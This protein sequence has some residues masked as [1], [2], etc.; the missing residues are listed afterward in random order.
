[1]TDF[2]AALKRMS[3]N[4]VERL[5]KAALGES[6]WQGAPSVDWRRSKKL[7]QKMFELWERTE[8]NAQRDEQNRY[9]AASRKR[10]AEAHEK[11]MQ[12]PET[13]KLA[14]MRASRDAA[15]TLGKPWFP[16]KD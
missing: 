4:D 12:D 2:M 16:D 15:V 6:G 10:D 5:A 1:M 14:G 7:K 9:F 3:S 13:R 8:A 11:A